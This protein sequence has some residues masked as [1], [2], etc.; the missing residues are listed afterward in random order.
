MLKKY[1]FTFPKKINIPG[2]FTGNI[3]TICTEMKI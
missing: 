1:T 2:T 3:S